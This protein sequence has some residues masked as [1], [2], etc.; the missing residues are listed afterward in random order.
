MQTSMKTFVQQ[1]KS[2]SNM[3]STAHV[4]PNL[5]CLWLAISL[6][7]SLSLLLLYRIFLTRSAAQTFLEPQVVSSWRHK[8]QWHTVMRWGIS[9]HITHTHIH[10]IVV[11]FSLPKHLQNFVQGRKKSGVVKACVH[12]VWFRWPTLWFKWR[13]EGHHHRMYR[14]WFVFMVLS[15]KQQQ[16][17][18]CSQMAVLMSATAGL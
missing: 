9:K 16:Q 8:H 14:D 5:L 15:N 1:Y 13:G 4:V 17:R 18:L 2:V 11:C 12:H 6:C 10:R 7:A 3:W